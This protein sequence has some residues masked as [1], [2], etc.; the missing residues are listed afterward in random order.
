MTPLL[1]RLA[2]R[3]EGCLPERSRWPH[4]APGALRASRP[5]V[6]RRGRHGGCRRGRG[7]LG[8]AGR[9][10]PSRSSRA[11]GRPRPSGPDLRRRR[12]SPRRP[13]RRVCSPCGRP[14]PDPVA[15]RSLGPRRHPTDAAGGR[16]GPSPPE[17]RRGSGRPGRRRPGRM[18][19]PGP[20][21]ARR[22]A[23]ALPAVRVS[24]SPPS[25][26]PVPPIRRPG[27]GPGADTP[28]EPDVVQATIGPV[29]VRAAP[30]PAPVH[31]RPACPRRSGRSSPSL[32]DYLRGSGRRD[33]Q[34][35]GPGRDDGGAAQPARQRHDRRRPGC[36][37]GHG[38]AVAPDPIELHDPALGRGSTSSCTGPRNGL[39]SNAGRP[40]RAGDGTLVTN[41]PLRR[42]STTCSRPT[43]R[44][45][46]RPRSCSATRCRCWHDYPVLDRP[47]IRTA[48]TRARSG[49]RSCR[50]RS[51]RC[52]PPT[53]PT[54]R[55]RSRSPSSRWTPRRWPGCGG[56]PGALPSD[57]RVRRLGG[58]DRVEQ[59]R[60]RRPAGAEPGPGR[61]GHADRAR[62]LVEPDP[63]PRRRW[64]SPWRLPASNRPH[65]WATLHLAVPTSTALRRGSAS[66]T[67]CCGPDRGRG[68]RERRPDRPRRPSAL[69]EPPRPGVAGGRRSVT[70]RLR[71][72]GEKRRPR[73]QRRGDG[74]GAAA[75]RG[76]PP[77][78]HGRPPAWYVA[79]DV[80]REARPSQEAG[81]PW[82]PT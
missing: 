15:D 37:L 74:A 79:L 59:A 68:A 34:P 49:R 11:G 5:R 80:H 29:E 45:I 50:R 31:R 32:G 67:R 18:P 8:T 16:P 35:P 57:G 66:P 52:R 30:A 24:A 42:T 40:T 39:A 65:R 73:D 55:R 12:T 20:A 64:C 46:S 75:R 6:V 76:R 62:R 1:T 7:G 26:L 33:E 41:P 71:R 36:R 27:S 13:P 69:R 54:R 60:A 56:H 38:H 61:P 19:L 51:R 78:S 2:R 77:R 4:R 3:A 81:L 10:H 53:S 14:R 63:S 58:A 72:A 21:R 23:A 82:A 22:G 28:P 25:S 70:V 43:P 44:A 9:R 47:A 17:P 48:L